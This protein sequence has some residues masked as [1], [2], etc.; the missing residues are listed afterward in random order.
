MPS[1]LAFNIREWSGKVKRAELPVDQPP[2]IAF[3]G[4]ENVWPRAIET[5]IGPALCP[6]GP[7]RTLTFFSTTLH[8]PIKGFYNISP[9]RM[10]NLAHTRRDTPIQLALECRAPLPC[11]FQCPPYKIALA[12]SLHSQ[13]ILQSLS[14]S[15]VFTTDKTMLSIELLSRPENY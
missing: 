13:C 15:S 11:L 2:T 3:T 8:L 5:E 10:L 12:I 7:G 6:I 1:R 9:Y 4:F 14:N